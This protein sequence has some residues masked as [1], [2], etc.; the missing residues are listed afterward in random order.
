MQ[1][2]LTRRERGHRLVGIGSEVISVVV[3]LHVR[4]NGGELCVRVQHESHRV[5]DHIASNDLGGKIEACRHFNRIPALEANAFARDVEASFDVLA[6]SLEWR[7]EQHLDKSLGG[8][9]RA[10]GAPVHMG[11]SDAVCDAV[12]DEEER[13][14]TK[15][16]RIH[17]RRQSQHVFAMNHFSRAL[18]EA[19]RETKQQSDG[20]V[21]DTREQLSA[22]TK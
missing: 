8:M 14:A 19:V 9:V 15:G 22:V 21:L 2:R 10:D 12:L 1:H 6:Y 5:V 17:E 13:V 4:E 18:E 11:P 20:S 3:L 7:L 16:R